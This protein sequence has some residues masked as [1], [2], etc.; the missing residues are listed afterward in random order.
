MFSEDD[1][2]NAEMVLKWLP[3]QNYCPNAIQKKAILL[4]LCSWSKTSSTILAEI[5]Q[6][7][8]F[9]LWLSLSI[10]ALK[11]C[12][13]EFCFFLTQFPEWE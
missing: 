12:E 5:Q 7:W 3:E 6:G 4:C 13:C 2:I 11:T 1:N 10:V 8:L 9:C